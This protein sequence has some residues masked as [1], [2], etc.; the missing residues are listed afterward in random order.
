MISPRLTSIGK[1]GNQTLQLING[2]SYAVF[3]E[4]FDDKIVNE[5]KDEMARVVQET[6]LNDKR[7]EVFRAS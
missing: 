5:L 7:I 2:Y 6:D 1:M 3:N 4:I